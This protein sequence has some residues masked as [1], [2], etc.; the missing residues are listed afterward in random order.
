MK[1]RVLNLHKKSWHGVEISDLLDVCCCEV[2]IS[3]KQL[4]PLKTFSN[5]FL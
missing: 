5:Q 1:I 2:F 4:K 3:L